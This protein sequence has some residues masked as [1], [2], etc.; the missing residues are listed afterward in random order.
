MKK[1]LFHTAIFTLIFYFIG[2]S[3]TEAVTKSYKRANKQAYFG[4][5]LAYNTIGGDFDGT[6]YLPALTE[7]IDIPDLDNG[8]GF[9]LTLGVSGKI[10]SL[11]AISFE[12][13]FQFSS[14][15]FAL[16][17]RNDDAKY[18]NFDFN[19]KGIY[20]PQKVQPYLLFGISVPYLNIHNAAS[21]GLLV[22]DAKF[23]G[24]GANLGAGVDLYINPKLFLN[25]NAIYRLQEIST[26]EGLGDRL[27]ITGGLDN[28][29]FNL[30]VGIMYAIPLD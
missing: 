12:T 21:S 5:A 13:A 18:R 6:V 17:G 14:H 4:L 26:V 8:F 10:S 27:E 25:F 11:W 3:L 2:F 16:S 24:V 7:R 1:Y 15:S 20:T 30:S 29:N 22:A 19:I 23:R 9:G 28:S